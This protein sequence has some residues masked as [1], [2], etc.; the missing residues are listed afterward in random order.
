M[1]IL[2]AGSVFLLGLGTA[3]KT[4]CN[5]KDS[6][7]SPDSKSSSFVAEM[8]TENSVS[9]KKGS[10][11]WSYFCVP[12]KIHGFAAAP[13]SSEMCLFF[14]LLRIF[15]QV[16]VLLCFLPRTVCLHLVLS[17]GKQELGVSFKCFWKS[18]CV[19]NP[20]CGTKWSFPVS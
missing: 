15:Q 20:I 8:G 10:Q 18:W 7:R 2:P 12:V 9:I 4:S 14:F 5:L 17:E 3:W 6:L 19:F 16:F 13:I 11:P 1:G